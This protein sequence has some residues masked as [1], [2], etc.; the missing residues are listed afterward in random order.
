MSTSIIDEST[1]KLKVVLLLVLSVSMVSSASILILTST[2]PSLVKVF[3]RTL[4]GS[5]FMAMIGAA[6]GDL[7]ALRTPKVRNNL[8][9]LAGIGVILSLHFSTWFQS[10]EMT[11]IAA[12]VVLVDSSPIFTAIFS[13][14]FLGESIRRRS[15]AGIFV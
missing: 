15:W 6:R 1:S 14:I 5:L 4:Y 10:L 7:S 3:W 8:H 12:S 9:W 2:S 11:S 13:T